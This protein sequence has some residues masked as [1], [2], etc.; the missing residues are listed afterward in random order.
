LGATICT[1][2]RPACALCPWTQPCTARRRGDPETFPRKAPKPEGGLRFGVSFVAKRADGCVLVRN[3][4]T[5]GLLGGMAEVPSTAWAHD[6]N[7]RHA[8]KEAPLKARWRRV[9]GR[10]EHGFTHFRL[11]QIVYVAHVAARTR[12]PAG[13]RWVA[14]GDLR[15][16]A[17]PTIMRKV[18]AHAYPDL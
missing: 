18:L 9:P 3:R 17:W 12:A 8:L 2:K 6:F 14:C 10:V 5:H 4:P 1:A 13:M 16:E 11:Q 7:E 15:G